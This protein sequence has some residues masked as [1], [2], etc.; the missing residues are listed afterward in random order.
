MKE[1]RHIVYLMFENRSFDNLLGWLYDG[2]TPLNKINLSNPPEYMGLQ[3]GTFYNLAKDGTKKYVVKGTQ[4]KMN[5][6][7][8]DPHEEYNNV[9]NQL[10]GQ[11]DN[12]ADGKRADMSGFYQDYKTFFDDPLES[13]ETYAPS[14]LPVINGLAR[15]YAVCDY[16]FSSVPTQTNANRAFSMA[17]N[18]LGISDEGRLVG[19]VNN[20]RTN[21]LSLAH[22]DGRQFNQK[23]FLHVL[24]ENGMDDW[25]VYHSI[26]AKLENLLGVEGY[27]YTRALME[28]LQ[29]DE[30][31][32]HFDT[33]DTF[34]EK[35]KVNGLP[36]VSILEPDWG[37]KAWVFGVNGND[38]HPP[39]NVSEGEK[40]L[41][42]VYEALKENQDVWEKTLFI[43]N[44][45]EHGGT[46]DHVS[47]PW[48]A[49]V[50]W[51]GKSATP[52][53][54]ILEC[55]FGFDRYGV[56]V[57]LLLISPYVEQSTVFRAKGPL[58][59]DHASVIATILKMQGIKKEKWGLGNRVYAAPTFED[60][61]T[62]RQPRT[63]SPSISVNQNGIETLTKKDV[64]RNDIHVTL[65]HKML[66]LSA[67]KNGYKFPIL[68]KMLTTLFSHSD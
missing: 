44:F 47:P 42:K 17:G 48:G 29:G 6:P 38:Y 4:N 28:S 30:W 43:V 56:R 24:S 55:E 58:P 14:E 19:M 12:P 46:Y 31:D 67:K 25:M 18:S 35:A 2:E 27:S 54:Q 7:I 36:A 26:G 33:M 68:K 21:L 1:I 16:Y 40:F 39:C 3:N 65:V 64:I 52:T 60:V 61:L 62:R 9:N 57:P 41:L 34:F 63:D 8:L 50:P 10:F 23:T 32:S 45:D 53:P 11:S 49:P 20:R 51:G 37:L 59:F 5:V 22:P 13:I 15:N 66:H